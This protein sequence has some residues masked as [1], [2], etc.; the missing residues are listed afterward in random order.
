MV[1]ST[2]T[3]RANGFKPNIALV[4]AIWTMRP[5]MIAAPI[6]YVFFSSSSRPIN[7]YLWT[8]K[9]N[10]IEE[11]L[12]NIFSLP[13]ALLFIIN[14]NDS[15]QG[16]CAYNYKYQEFWDAFYIVA[17]AGAVSL[18]LLVCMML[19]FCSKI[20]K[21]PY[22]AGLSRFWKWTLTISGLNMLLAFAG[23]WLLWSGK[24][25]RLLLITLNSSLMFTNNSFH[26]QCRYGFLPRKSPGR[27]CGVGGRSLRNCTR[28]TTCRRSALN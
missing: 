19:H 16:A 9:D 15:E 8:F 24:S 28:S 21:A 22:T 6:W 26:H 20:R 10:V 23:Q 5:R 11:T 13:F 1:I 12:L 25:Y 27:K 17:A 3:I 7:P 2:I 4:F 14:R 18:I